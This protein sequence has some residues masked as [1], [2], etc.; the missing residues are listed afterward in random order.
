MGT[1][2]RFDAS[3]SARPGRMSHHQRV[4]YV[5]ASD[6]VKL[7]WAET[8]AG[9]VL[10]KASNWLSHL[11]YDWESPIWNHWLRFFADRFRLVRYDERGCGM[12]DWS[13]ENLSFDRRLADLETVIEAAGIREPFALLGISQGAGICIAYA[14]RYPERVSR[15]VLYGGYAR[16]ARSRNDPEQDQFFRA[17]VDVIRVGWAQD[18]PA[19]RQVF[20]SRFI[21]GASNEQVKW[22]NDL[23]RKTAS[24]SG[25][26]ALLES[27]GSM[28]VVE[29]LPQVRTPTLVLHGRNDDVV[30]IAEGRLI[31]ALIPGAQF[32]ELD[33]RNHIL[34]EDEPAWQRFKNEVADFLGVATPATEDDVFASLSPREREILAR[35][36]EGL[37][38]AEIAERLGVS[39][40]TVRNHLSHLFD[41]LGVWSRAQAIV[42]ARDR[43]FKDAP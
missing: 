8:G 41:K 17:L 1:L 36:T 13:V 33:S 34:L 3:G 5:P 2:S 27:R 24:P 22:F 6:H 15:L 7:A 30:P 38:N 21:P 20:T 18:N 16:G 4:R 23:C 32:V 37:S 28:D 26:A 19:F 40:K 43:G 11:E 12:S 10:V 42:L 39:E 29:L 25:A 31:A 14:I 35:L 9:P